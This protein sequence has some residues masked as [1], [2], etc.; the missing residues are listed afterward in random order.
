MNF[1]NIFLAVA[2]IASLGLAACGEVPVNET[3]KDVQ[4]QR[5]AAAANSIQFTENA[6]IENIKRRLELTSNPGQIGFVLLMNEMGQPVAYM[7]VKGKVTSGGKR[8]TM[9]QV[10]KCLEYIGNSG[11]TWTVTGGP[12]DEG[13]YGHS[14][15]YVYFWTTEGQY[16]QWNGK[17]LYS[18]KPLRTSVP[19]LVVNSAPTPASK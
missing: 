2:A 3:A 8:L 19:P 14:A 10:V 6:E 5:A 18:D 12:S 11:C 9:P 15:E 16:V 13:T 17:Y 7:S 4:A 1:K